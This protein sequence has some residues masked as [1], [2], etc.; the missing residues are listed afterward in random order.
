VP[1][2]EEIR[3][4]ADDARYKTQGR[5]EKQLPPE[6]RANWDKYRLSDKVLKLYSDGDKAQQDI[7]DFYLREKLA[8]VGEVRRA[9]FL[10][11][12]SLF[13]YASSSVSGT[14]VSH[15]EN[16]WAQVERY[17]NDFTTFIKN[18]NSLLEKGAYFYL[19]DETISNK[20]IDFNA[21]PKFEDRLP[22]PGE[23]L[24]DGLPYLGLLALYNLFLFAFVFYKFQG[25]DVR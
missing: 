8:A 18:E 17:E 7:L 12:A 19:N 24:K 6:V 5:L 21:I 15:F 2:Q 13:E 22:R 11:P 1:T 9:N 10:S 23:R 3:Q 14:G 20:P 25:Y 4:K 16:L